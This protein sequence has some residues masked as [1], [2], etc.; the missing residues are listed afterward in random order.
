VVTH[1]VLWRFAD[2]AD[3]VEAKRLLDQM[4]PLVPQLRSLHVGVNRVDSPDAYHLVLTSTHDSWDELAGYVQHPE[5]V[6][7]SA[8]VREQNIACAVVDSED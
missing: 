4:L 8:Y 1:T 7:L 3:A 6:R 2:P 5:H